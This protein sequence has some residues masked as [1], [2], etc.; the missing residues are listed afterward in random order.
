MESYKDSE[1]LRR[2][3]I[4]AVAAVAPLFMNNEANAYL[5]GLAAALNQA[6]LESMRSVTNTEYYRGLVELLA[7]AHGR[8]VEAARLDLRLS[9]DEDVA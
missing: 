8:I 7:H 9:P 4:R 5:Q 3:D 1:N 2:K 6:D